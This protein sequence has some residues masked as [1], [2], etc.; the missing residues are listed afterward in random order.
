MNAA[1]DFVRLRDLRNIP[2]AAN[3]HR[4]QHYSVFGCQKVAP[5]PREAIV[6]R[7]QRTTEINYL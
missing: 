3:T 1:E 6:A 5:P 7:K 4:I 2:R